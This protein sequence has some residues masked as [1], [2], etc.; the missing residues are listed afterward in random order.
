MFSHTHK[1]K[2]GVMKKLQTLSNDIPGRHARSGKQC[3][4]SQP[5]CL[6][7]GAYYDSLVP[8]SGSRSRLQHRAHVYYMTRG[9]S[10][11]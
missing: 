5:P 10:V 6:L 2:R 8:D 11:L 9:V 1:T 7:L 3:V 4:L